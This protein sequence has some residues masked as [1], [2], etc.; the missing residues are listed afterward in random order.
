MLTNIQEIRPCASTRCYISLYPGFI[1]LLGLYHPAMPWISPVVSLRFSDKAGLLQRQES[2]RRRSLPGSP[3]RFVTKRRGAPRRVRRD[4]PPQRQGQ[5]RRHQRPRRDCTPT[6]VPF[7]YSEV[8]RQV[9]LSEQVPLD[10]VNN[11]QM[12]S[13][14]HAFIP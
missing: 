3:G 14:S 13:D 8:L 6:A 11:S 5:H 7:T 4:R 2:T 1:V 10:M 12:S 9:V